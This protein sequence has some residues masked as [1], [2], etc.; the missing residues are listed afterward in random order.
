MGTDGQVR[1]RQLLVPRSL[2][3]PLLQQLHA[4]PTAGH[5]RVIK[6]QDQ[7]MKMVYWRGWRADVALF[8]RRC[9]QFNRYLRHT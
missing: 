9:I 8:C 5:L 4:G 7:V 3:A 2:R 6:T 1:W